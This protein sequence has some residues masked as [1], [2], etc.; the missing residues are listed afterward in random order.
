VADSA[1]CGRAKSAR[2]FVSQAQ[3]GFLLAKG[4]HGTKGVTTAAHCPNTLS[5]SG[6]DLPFRQERYGYEYDIQSPYC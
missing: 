4:A 2:L 5:Y 3:E 1:K 6:V